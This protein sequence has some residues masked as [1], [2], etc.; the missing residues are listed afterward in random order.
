MHKTD[1][2]CLIYRLL[3]HK[4]ILFTLL[5]YTYLLTLLLLFHEKNLEKMKGL[6]QRESVI[7]A[8]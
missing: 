5:S 1:Y 7:I 8:Y 2:Y 3:L 4:L 6:I